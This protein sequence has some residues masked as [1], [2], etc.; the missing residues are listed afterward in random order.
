MNVEELKK[1]FPSPDNRFTKRLFGGNGR[2]NPIIPFDEATGDP[3]PQWPIDHNY[4]SGT[5]VAKPSGAGASDHFGLTT[6]TK[7][8]FDDF[9]WAGLEGGD[10]LGGDV[11]GGFNPCESGTDLNPAGQ[12]TPDY[13]D[14]THDNLQLPSGNAHRTYNTSSTAL[15]GKQE[16]PFTPRVVVPPNHH[17]DIELDA[18]K[19]NG[20]EYKV[21]GGDGTQIVTDDYYFTHYS[22]A[23]NHD[24]EADMPDENEMYF[25]LV[26]KRNP[27]H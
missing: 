9:G 2:L 24:N 18:F 5:G 20:H 10:D 14:L 4:G 25:W 13:S 21:L 19:L 11:G 15:I 23:R 7:V 22:D 16:S 3:G 27:C 17:T 26:I 8:N 1:S 6:F 12:Q